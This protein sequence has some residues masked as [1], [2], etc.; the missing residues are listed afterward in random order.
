MYSPPA[1][2]AQRQTRVGAPSREETNQMFVWLHPDG[3][4][5]PLSISGRVSLV[6]V[7][8]GYLRCHPELYEVHHG[9]TEVTHLDP[10]AFQLWGHKLQ[11]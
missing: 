7:D 1:L 10:I 11:P 5:V 9:T 3:T 2:L 8:Q 6:T 4:S